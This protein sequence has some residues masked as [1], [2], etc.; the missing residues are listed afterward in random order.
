MT[1]I[2]SELYLFI[3]SHF[4]TKSIIKTKNRHSMVLKKS[5]NYDITHGIILSFKS[6]LPI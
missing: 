5:A 6:F 1:N 2:P 4:L 3:S